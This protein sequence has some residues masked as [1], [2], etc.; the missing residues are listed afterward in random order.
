VPAHMVRDLFGRSAGEDLLGYDARDLAL[1]ATRAYAHL[2]GRTPGRPHIAISNPEPPTP[3]SRLGQVSVIEIVNDN[4]AFLVASVM[5]E[6]A[7]DGIEIKLVA[8]PIVSVERDGGG[9]LVAYRGLEGNGDAT[10]RESLI[11]LHVERMSDPVRIETLIAGLE[12]TLADVTVCVADWEAMTRSVAGVV[13]DLKSNPVLPVTEMAEAIQFLEWLKADN[14]TFLGLRE[15]SYVGGVADGQMEP[16]F[17]SGLGVL[18]NPDVRILRRGAE[19]VTMT[20]EMREFIMQP[21]PLIITKANVRSRVH[22]RVYMDYI[23]VKRFGADGNLVGEVRMVGLFTSTAYTRSTRTI[24]YLRRKVDKVLTR[25]GFDPESHSGKALVNVLE[26]FPRDELFQ[27]DDET[28]FRHA[29]AILQLDERPRVRV[30]ARPDRFDRFVSILVYV[31]RDRYDTNARLAIGTYLASV[32]KGRVS[33]FYPHY[34][35]GTLARVHFIIGRTDGETPVIS[36][37]VLEDAVGKIVRTWG[38]GLSEALGLIHEADKAGLL[39]RRYR[40]A[41][42]AAYR[43]AVSPE[44]AIG[45]I[46]ILET[47]SESHTLAIDFYRTAEA[48]KSE[49]AL[50]VFS[51]GRPI[52]LSERVPVLEAMGFAVVDERTYDVTPTD[53]GPEVYL[54]DMALSRPD[55]QAIDLDALGDKLGAMLIAVMTDEAESDGFNA[56]TL[57]AG[58]AWRDIAVLRTF[59]R[60]LRQIRAPYS[61]DYLW[62]TLR[63]HSGITK[64]VVLM[65]HLRFDPRLGLSIEERNAKQTDIIARLEEGLQAVTSLDEDR[66]LRAFSNLVQ[67]SIR[68]NFYQVTPEGRTRPTIS[69]KFDCKKIDNLP[70]PRPLFEIFVYSPRV[71]G[72]HLRFGKVARGGLRWSDRPQDFRT[73]VLGL[74]KAQQVKNAVIVPVGAKGGFVPKKLPPASQREAWFAEGTEAYKIFVRSLLELTDNIDGDRIIPP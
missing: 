28:L 50:K 21:V 42:S 31:P 32:F 23:G 16:E 15:Y 71:E 74:V 29:L 53:G 49:A 18:R 2:A 1:L 66:I 59:A 27:I 64:G 26:S 14:F 60:V 45:D 58:L 30:L 67:A 12:A 52:P 19:L 44:R 33:A 55:G 17:T 65:F 61:Q 48:P 34:P 5:G 63:K 70:A 57:E 62:T 7:A 9:A 11:H 37:E 46:R 39:S 41:F 4:M 43:E 68:T 6:L 56:L 20:P 69:V 35:E 54:H 38:D 24:P 22:R 3:G 40:G 25:A 47:L 72:L 51:R 8:H 10:S 73:E 13:E 36:R